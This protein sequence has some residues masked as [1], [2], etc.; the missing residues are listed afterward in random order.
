MSLGYAQRLS[1]NDNKG[2]LGMPEVPDI[3]GEARAKAEALAGVLG[4]CRPGRATVFTGA[5]VSTPCGIPDFRSPGGIWTRE[6]ANRRP[7]DEGEGESEGGAPRAAGAPPP[8]STTSAAPAPSMAT[9]VPS[10][11]HQV[12]RALAE[13]GTVGLVVSQN[14]DGLHLRSG[15]DPAVLAELHGNCF[16]EVCAGCGA[17]HFRDFEAE[18]VGEV[19]TGNA[20]DACGRQELR[21]TVLD[22]DGE[23]PDEELKRTERATRMADVVL[24]L[25]TSLQIQP[26]AD[27]PE[28]VRHKRRRKRRTHVVELDAGEEE[29]DDEREARERREADEARD[30]VPGHLAI[31]NLQAT[32]KD[33][34]AS[35]VIRARCDAVMALV[36]RRLALCVPAYRRRDRIR[37]TI[38]AWVDEESGARRFSAVAANAGDGRRPLP[39]LERAD[40]CDSGGSP[41]AWR[42]TLPVH[43]AAW[44]SW[45]RVANG[46]AHF[47]LELT[48]REPRLPVGARHAGGVFVNVVPI[49]HPV[50]TTLPIISCSRTH[51]V[52]TLHVVYDLDDHLYAWA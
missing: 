37:V 40:V 23:L 50:P 14:V 42:D 3:E 45:L 38:S 43:D 11:C 5:G 51:E 44:P 31:V 28:R 26:A 41:G 48:L 52:E 36:A 27:I 9:A 6:A 10:L 12:V 39:W 22:W 30:M 46:E 13:A 34:K 20:C 4:G 24:T 49:V 47:R 29:S 35:L 25:G 1:R 16:L 21:D 15:M 33:K 19:L 18:T 32:P 17:R 2:V 8:A 7:G